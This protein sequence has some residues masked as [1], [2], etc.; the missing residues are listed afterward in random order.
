MLPGE[1]SYILPLPGLGKF[2][3]TQVFARVQWGIDLGEHAEYLQD[4]VQM[5]I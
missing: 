2:G 3:L 4:R 1:F 5:D